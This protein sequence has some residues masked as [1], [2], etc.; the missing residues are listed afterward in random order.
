MGFYHV[1]RIWDICI[2][3]LFGGKPLCWVIIKLHILGPITILYIVLAS[4]SLENED[5][6]P[7]GK[8]NFLQGH[9]RYFFLLRVLICKHLLK[10]YFCP[11]LLTENTSVIN[12][13][14]HS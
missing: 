11:G 4:M 8:L 13:G 14:I 1:K 10:C 12:Y 7:N 9:L 6:L 3:K 5:W 2:R